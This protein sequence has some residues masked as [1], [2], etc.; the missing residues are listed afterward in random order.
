MTPSEMRHTA[1]TIRS[2]ASDKAKVADAAK[3]SFWRSR[4][5]G[6]A[7]PNAPTYASVL[8]SKARRLED[9]AMMTERPICSG[10]DGPDV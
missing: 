7:H 1:D 9:V 10:V 3:S 4:V 5:E 8:Q 6:T 2:I